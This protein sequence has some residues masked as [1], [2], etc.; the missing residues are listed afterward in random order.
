MVRV[1][2]PK[3]ISRLSGFSGI[4]SY[5]VCGIDRDLK[6][7]IRGFS[8]SG[9][10]MVVSIYLDYFGITGNRV[11]V[12]YPTSGLPVQSARIASGLR[13]NLFLA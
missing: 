1:S 8:G 4:F 10:S 3:P 13:N 12:K 2:G 11:P 9:S 7:G 6:P 5:Q